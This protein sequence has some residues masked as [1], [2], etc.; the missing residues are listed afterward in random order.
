[1]PKGFISIKINVGAIAILRAQQ[2][3]N[4]TQEFSLFSSYIP[5]L[6]HQ[7]MQP[8]TCCQWPQKK[9]MMS[10]RIA[11][12]TDSHAS[13]YLCYKCDPGLPWRWAVELLSPGL[14]CVV[15][16][17]SLSVSLLEHP[18]TGRSTNT[19]ET[20][21]SCRYAEI[22]AHSCRLPWTSMWVIHLWTC[23]SPSLYTLWRKCQ[24]G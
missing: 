15:S 23:G 21:S 24:P 9:Y 10:S 6:P 16:V 14:V 4:T 17:P 5:L 7:P 20:S 1:M 18:N 19:W 8:R 2:G 11:M 13:G 12:A 22:G 3:T